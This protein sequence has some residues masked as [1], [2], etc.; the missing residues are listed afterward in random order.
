MHLGHDPSYFAGQRGQDLGGAGEIKSIIGMVK[1]LW[2]IESSLGQSQESDIVLR[3]RPHFGLAHQV[4]AVLLHVQTGREV[5]A[6]P[7]VVTVVETGRRAGSQD[8][9]QR[10]RVEGRNVFMGKCI[11][12]KRH[13]FELGYLCTL[14]TLTIPVFAG[15]CHS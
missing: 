11:V 13:N 8:Q 1:G 14:G 5:V 2:V 4:D 9:I 7:L 3:I 10:R 15:I 12:M 6:I